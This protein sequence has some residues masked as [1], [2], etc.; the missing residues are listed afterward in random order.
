MNSLTAF[1]SILTLVDTL[2]ENDLGPLNHAPSTIPFLSV[3]IISES[4]YEPPP[5]A[6]EFIKFESFIY[7]G[8]R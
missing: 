2:C 6:P 7:I 3:K 8:L 4:L 1:G 5:V